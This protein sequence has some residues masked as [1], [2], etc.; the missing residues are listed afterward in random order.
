VTFNKQG[1]IKNVLITKSFGSFMHD[2]YARAT[3]LKVSYPKAV[4]G[5]EIT[6]ALG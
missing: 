5:K 4:W 1:S 2:A 6:I 3:V